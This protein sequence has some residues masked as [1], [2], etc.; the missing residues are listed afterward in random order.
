MAETKKRIYVY[1]NAKALLIL[2]VVLGHAADYYTATYDSLKVFFIFAYLFHMPL[3]IFIA[4]LFSKSSLDSKYFRREK[5]ANF[6]VLYLLL[7]VLFYL[8]RYYI[9]GYKGATFNP[10]IEDGVPWFMFAMAMW[11]V[12]GR[13]FRNISKFIVLPLTILWA[14]A[15]GFIPVGDYLVAARI[16]VFFPYFLVGYY[17]NQHSLEE[18]LKSRVLKIIG[19]VF[20]LLVFTTLCFNIDTLYGIRNVLSGRNSYFL[21]RYTSGIPTSGLILKIIVTLLTICISISI[22]ALMPQK[23]TWFT[24]VGERSLAIYFFHRFILSLYHRYEVNDYLKAAFP[25]GW[26]WIYMTIF[27]GVTLLLALKPFDFILTLI[28]RIVSAIFKRKQIK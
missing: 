26:L 13:L 24:V 25:N 9:L 3:F 5:F 14:L 28:Q 27:V 8:L 1:D 4:G 16:I 21:I 18:A 11:L 6:I 12:L 19:G 2:L 10:F 22:L 23:R 17:I 15:I 7:E 20:L